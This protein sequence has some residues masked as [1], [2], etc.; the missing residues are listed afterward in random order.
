MGDLYSLPECQKVR[1]G[2]CD[3]AVFIY[4]VLLLALIQLKE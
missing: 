1:Q 3:E 4:V 2:K